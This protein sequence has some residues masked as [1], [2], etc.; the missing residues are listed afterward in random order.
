MRLTKNTNLS[1]S[2]QKTMIQVCD[3]VFKDREGEDKWKELNIILG[4][5]RRKL[6]RKY[7]KLEGVKLAELCPLAEQIIQDDPYLDEQT[8]MDSGPSC[9]GG[10]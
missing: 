3:E 5:S 7:W 4:R 2:Y 8:I 6:L 10:A 9:F 1:T